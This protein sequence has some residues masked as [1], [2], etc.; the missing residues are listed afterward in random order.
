MIMKKLNDI[1]PAVKLCLVAAIIIFFCMRTASF[2]ERTSAAIRSLFGGDTKVSMLDAVIEDISPIQ[3]LTTARYSA[4]V[5]VIK[6]YASRDTILTVAITKKGEAAYI[7][8]GEVRAGIDFRDITR[9]SLMMS[10]DTLYVTMPQVKILDAI[11]NPGGITL[12]DESGTVPS[13]KTFD[14]VPEAKNSIVSK[15]I[16]K[17]ILDQARE[18]AQKTLSQ[19]FLASGFKTVVF[20]DP[21]GQPS[22]GP[23]ALP[24]RD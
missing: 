24:E 7:V 15:A 16:S 10:G 9:E 13:Q 2:K 6:K 11:V 5:P 4:E 18:S 22:I 1:L 12:F 17:G 8:K 21:V 3:E 20:T 14:F 19:I 23:L